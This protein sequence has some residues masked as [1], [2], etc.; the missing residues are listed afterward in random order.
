MKLIKTRIH[1]S[2]DS[3]NTY[4]SAIKKINKLTTRILGIS[5]LVIVISSFTFVTPPNENEE[6][7]T[8]ENLKE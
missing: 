8:I 4:R 1:N 2:T 6:V 7:L 3:V 5:F